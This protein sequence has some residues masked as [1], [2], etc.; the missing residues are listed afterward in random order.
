MNKINYEKTI[1]RYLFHVRKATRTQ[2]A[3]ALN[4]RKNTVGSV[5]NEL[6][7]CK[8]VIELVPFKKRNTL[9]KLNPDR[10]YSI[11]I[12]HRVD[13]LLFLIMN[14]D[15]EILYRKKISMNK[16][17]GKERV[18]RII[19]E[20]K[21]S[22]NESDIIE[23]KILGIG[24]SDFIPHD[25]GTGL[26]TKSI[27]MPGWGD[28]NIKRIIENKL[29]LK[30]SI[31]R[32]TDAFSLAEHEFGECKEIDPFMVVQLDRGI[33][34]S[35]YMKGDYLKGTTDIF[36]ELGHIVYR[37]DGEICKC[38][39]RGCLES[40][41]GI[42][43]LL[44]KIHSNVKKGVYFKKVSTQKY[45]SWDDVVSNAEDGNKLTLLIINEAAKA[46]GDSLAVIVNILGI[47]RIILYGELTK[48]GE[49]LLN[50][51]EKSIRNHCIYPLNE[52]TKVTISKLD[53]YG[54]AMGAA[55]MVMRD[56]FNK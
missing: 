7:K 12:E 54:S 24:F 16:V 21:A 55:Y 46:V 29:K 33:G 3:D 53:E 48:L 26:K 20:I 10:Y 34:L 6:I 14:S 22:I 15:F 13:V 8:I 41:A 38:G 5:C 4:I 44:K 45:I 52:E 28:I 27:W 35:V 2:I 23:S 31:L 56:Y 39:N 36:G 9:L 51:I 1:L 40:Y 18:N 32:C 30:T 47:N 25:I 49:L 17:Y 50:Q 19:D 37:D 42:D 43:S 11:G